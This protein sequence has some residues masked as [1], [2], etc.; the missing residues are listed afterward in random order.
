MGLL[1]TKIYNSHG[2]DAFDNYKNVSTCNEIA[3]ISVQY[4]EKYQLL[5]SI[6]NTKIFS[7]E[8]YQKKWQNTNKLLD[9]GFQGIKTGINQTSGPCLSAYYKDL[10]IIVLNSRSMNERWA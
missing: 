10:I 5:K 3:K 4:M 7:V 6:A 2:N 1:Y 9:D 8:R